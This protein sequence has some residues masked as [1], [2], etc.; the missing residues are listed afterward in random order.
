MSR[1][2]QSCDTH[3][4]VLVDSHDG[5]TSIVDSEAKPSL[6]RK[7]QSPTDKIANDIA[8]AYKYVNRVISLVTV[9][10]MNVFSE[11]GFYSRSFDEE[12]L[13]HKMLQSNIKC[14]KVA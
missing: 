13:E 14:C 12:I 5:N 7:L 1:F 10:P 9:G 11:S 2:T 4:T 8:M 3:V 6:R